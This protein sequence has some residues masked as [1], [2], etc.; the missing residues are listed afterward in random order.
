[1][2]RIERLRLRLP[3]SMRPHAAL[4][5]RQVADSLVTATIDR[6]VHMDSCV[7]PAIPAD[8]ALGPR[9]IADAA[10]RGIIR[11]LKGAGR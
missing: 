4:I 6:T 11:H 2:I 8:P 10:S 7:V 5:A 1:M 9:A 3:A